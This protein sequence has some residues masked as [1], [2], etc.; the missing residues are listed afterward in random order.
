[1]DAECHVTANKSAFAAE[2][3][4]RWFAAH[5]LRTPLQ[6]IQ[7]G[8][9]LLLEERAA[10]LSALQLEALSLIATATGDLERCIANLSELAA[11][12]TIPAPPP[13]KL[14]L[15]ALL[16]PS[17]HSLQLLC[18]PQLAAWTTLDVLVAPQLAN[19]ALHHLTLLARSGELASGLACELETVQDDA[20]TL[21]LAV[22]PSASG[23]GAV[24]W[25][26]ATA[27]MRH[28]GAQLQPSQTATSRLTLRRAP[29]VPI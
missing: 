13:E 4:T 2:N 28:A 25:R 21:T 19:R 29:Q 14:P 26:L 3:A 17:E 10:A 12:D 11:L 23:D 6:G 8:L 22:A 20:I 1:M 27:L 16:A 7:G 24:V 5:E 9:A 15:G 18:G